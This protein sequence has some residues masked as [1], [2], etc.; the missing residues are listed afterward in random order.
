MKKELLDILVCPKT[1]STL[2]PDSDFDEDKLTQGYLKSSKDTKYSIFHSIPRFVSQ[3]NYTDSFGMQWNHFAQ[4][5]LDSFSGLPISAER[6]WNATNWKPSDLN[7]QWIL[8][9]G[10]GSGRFAEIAL[11]AGHLV[12]RGNK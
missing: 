3:T 6:F 12:A 2:L 11:K 8:D 1:K 5:Q 4:T 10:C 7:G 9:V